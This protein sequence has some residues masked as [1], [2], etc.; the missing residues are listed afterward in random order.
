V[1]RRWRGYLFAARYEYAYDPAEATATPWAI[2]SCFIKI[3]NGLTFLVPAYP[4]VV[5]KQAVK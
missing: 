1:T 5:K 4:V 2:I 3:Q